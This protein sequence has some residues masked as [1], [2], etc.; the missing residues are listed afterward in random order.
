[1]KLISQQISKLVALVLVIW[2][3]GAA[4]V[5]CCETLPAAEPESCS[6]GDH[7]CCKKKAAEG[8]EVSASFFRQES[9]A[10]CCRYSIPTAEPAQKIAY[11]TAP[12]LVPVD[13]QISP[14]KFVFT[15]TEIKQPKTFRPLALNRGSTYLKNCV[16][17][18]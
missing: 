5:F 18:I 1:M 8:N 13:D 10:T 16:F 3:S 7:S 2:L 17:R 14:A 4:C 11:S 15:S 12:A 6:M 9:Q